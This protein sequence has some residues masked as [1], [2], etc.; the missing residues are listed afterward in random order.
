MS[1]VRKRYYHNSVENKMFE[2]GKQPKGW[3]LGMLPVT[4]EEREK[5][6]RKRKK[7]NLEKYGTEFPTQSK[8][9]KEKYR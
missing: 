9:V 7:T 3:V 8:K 4:K 1:R 2:E 5:R 6:S